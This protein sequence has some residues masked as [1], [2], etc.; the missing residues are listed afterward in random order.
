ENAESKKP[1][2]PCP[3]PSPAWSPTNR[4]PQC[5]RHPRS[6]ALQL[7]PPSSPPNPDPPSSPPDPV[8]RQVLIGSSS[9]LAS[10][11]GLRL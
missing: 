5:R 10:R 4:G 11:H 7:L 8:T 6:S 1:S 3:S 9:L 2:R